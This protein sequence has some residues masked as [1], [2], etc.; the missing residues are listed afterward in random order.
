MATMA[1]V[2]LMAMRLRVVASVRN[3]WSDI[4]EGAGGGAADGSGPKTRK[5]STPFANGLTAAKPNPAAATHPRQNAETS[6]LALHQRHVGLPGGGVDGD[7]VREPPRPDHALP[8]VVDRLK[9]PPL[10]VD[11]RVEVAVPVSTRNGHVAGRRTGR[12]SRKLELRLPRPERH[13]RQLERAGVPKPDVRVA[14]AGERTAARAQHRQRDDRQ[15]SHPSAGPRLT[16][17]LRPPQVR[18]PNPRCDATVTVGQWGEG[19]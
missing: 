16:A 13:R 17:H 3:R 7:H 4:A 9:H 14:F 1:A 10:A 5:R 8:N 6:G 15:S 19:R 18:T 2:R 12:D 11:E